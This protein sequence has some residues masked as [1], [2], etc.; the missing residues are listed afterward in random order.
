MAAPVAGGKGLRSLI[1]FV[2]REIWVERNTRIFQ[3]KEQP[4]NRVLNKI[5]DQTATWITAGA[6]HLESFVYAA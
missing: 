6:K 5:K 2:L 4:I 1:I 3:H